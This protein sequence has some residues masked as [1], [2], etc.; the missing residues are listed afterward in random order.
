MMDA[1]VLK[2]I[3]DEHSLWVW[4]A[5]EKGSRANLCGANLCEAN[6]S[7]ADLCGAYLPEANLCEANLSGADLCG[8]Y[9]PEANLCEANLCGAN[10]CGAN[11]R[12][13]N[14]RGANLRGAY[15][16]EA[17]LCEANLCGANLCGAN[18]CEANL[19]GAKGIRVITP[20]GSRGDILKAVIHADGWHIYTGC[21]GGTL[22]EF[23]AAV[24]LEHASDKWGVLYRAD[25][26]ML[27]ATEQVF[28]DEMK[29]SEGRV[30]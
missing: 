21:F 20:D 18:L 15:L 14:L 30:L 28:L 12:R 7:W 17:N 4:S 3:L 26:T 11:L 1:E 19:Y 10:L 27:R 9:L 6:L 22:P 5:H 16:C 29:E 25:I 8:A 24:E 13:A 23:E 2:R